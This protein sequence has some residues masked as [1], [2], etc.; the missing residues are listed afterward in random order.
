M[1]THNKVAKRYRLTPLNTII[2]VCYICGKVD[3]YQNDGHN[4]KEE[5]LKQENLE[6]YD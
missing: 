2:Q 3:A 6:Y 5:T 4:C 1:K